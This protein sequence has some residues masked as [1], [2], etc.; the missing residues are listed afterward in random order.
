MADGG[1]RAALR[2]F[3]LNLGLGEGGVRLSPLL[4]LLL[5]TACAGGTQPANCPPPPDAATMALLPK[6]GENAP[7][8]PPPAGKLEHPV[9]IVPPLYPSCALQ[10]HI[11]GYVDFAFTLEA[12]GSVGDFK[13][14]KEMPAGFGFAA[15]GSAVFGQWKF[16]PHLV[17]GK[18]VA[19]QSFYRFTWKLN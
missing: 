1:G 6:M 2:A 5:L 13:V 16:P 7:S 17:D 4:V 18:A 8:V 10:M 9:K 15:A 3:K 12:D 14:T 19:A 11:N